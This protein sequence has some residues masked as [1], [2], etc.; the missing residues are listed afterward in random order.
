MKK[1]TNLVKFISGSPQFRIN[2]TKQEDAPSYIFYSQLELNEDLTGVYSTKDEK[3]EIRTFD[4]VNLVEEGDVIF[5]L[6]SGTA[7]IVGKEHEGYLYTQNY[8]KIVPSEKLDSRYLV[9]L[10]NE[11]IEIKKQFAIG[12]QGSQVM[13]YTLS[14]VKDLYIS[15][16]PDI[17]KQRLI[18]RLYF[19]QLRINSL[20]VRVADHESKI[21]L[22]KLRGV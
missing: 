22:K 6:I 5:S 20:K 4:E 10:I 1:I 3:R 12:L 13:K 17:S 15:S 16:L 21:L 8:V 9:Y 19:N 11:S 2:E 14:Q 18:G 7:S